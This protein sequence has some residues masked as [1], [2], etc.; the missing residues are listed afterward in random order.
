VEVYQTFCDILRGLL[1]ACFDHSYKNGRLSD[2]QQEGLISLLLKQDRSDKQRFSPFKR[3][4]LHFIVVMQKILT[5]RIPHE[6]KK[7][8]LDIIH[9]NQTV[10]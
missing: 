3:G 10:F 6:I 2:T 9:P 1:L 4:P 7:V 8:L 5:N